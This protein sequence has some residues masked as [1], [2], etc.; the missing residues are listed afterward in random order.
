MKFAT[1]AGAAL[2][3]SATSALALVVP[4]D[5]GDVVARQLGAL[6]GRAWAEQ[7][8]PRAA[9]QERIVW[10][11]KITQPAQSQVFIAGEPFVIEWYVC[12]PASCLS[13]PPAFAGS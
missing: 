1:F 12:S 9:L 3:A 10:N 4:R 5:N 2:A 6:S 13:C 11:P 8:E 7:I